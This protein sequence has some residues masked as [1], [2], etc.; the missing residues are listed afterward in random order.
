MITDTTLHFTSL[1]S[2]MIRFNSLFIPLL[3]PRLFLLL[4]TSFLFF[5]YLSEAIR[6]LLTPLITSPCSPF[7]PDILPFSY[8]FSSSCIFLFVIIFYST[9]VVVLKY[10][11]LPFLV[12]CFLLFRCYLLGTASLCYDSYRLQ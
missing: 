1:H 10:L 9:R 11:A 2:L 6:A 3:F 8:S 12:L 7:L 5:A 4:Y